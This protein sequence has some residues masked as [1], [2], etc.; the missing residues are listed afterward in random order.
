MQSSFYT[1][2]TRIVLLSF[3]KLYKS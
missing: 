2:L 3:W 1:S